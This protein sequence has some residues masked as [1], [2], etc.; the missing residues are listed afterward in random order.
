MGEMDNIHTNTIVTRS[1]D[2]V[3]SLMDDEIVILNVRSG[4][5]F[6]L[7]N[8]GRRIWELLEDP[9]PVN[10]IIRVVCLEYDVEQ[11]RCQI[12]VLNLIGH[13]QEAAL[14]TL[15]DQASELQPGPA[16]TENGA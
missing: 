8:V 4:K 10:E 2:Q 6:N 11:E 9:I 14:V 12:D 7:K 3:S 16:E 15:P 5:Y 1:P 13:L